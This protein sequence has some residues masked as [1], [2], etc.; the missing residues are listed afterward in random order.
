MV[1]VDVSRATSGRLARVHFDAFGAE[2]DFHQCPVGPHSDLFAKVQGRHRIQSSGNLNVMIEGLQSLQRRLEKSK[3]PVERG[4]LKRQIERLLGKN[5]RAAG[6]FDV[7]IVEDK[8]ACAK[9]RL[10]WSERT[11]WDQWAQ[12]SEGCYLLR[13]NVH[14]WTP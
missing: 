12:H 7:H 9:L 8:Q 11:E 1:I 4:P 14:D 10:Q 2:V 6:K 13:T 3:K 5:S